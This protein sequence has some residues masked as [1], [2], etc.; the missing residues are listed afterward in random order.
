MTPFVLLLTALAGWALLTPWLRAGPCAGLSLGFLAATFFLSVEMFVFDLVGIGWNR[1]ALLLPW[2]VALGWF[3]YAQ[4]KSIAPPKL[5]WSKPNLIAFVAVAATF[6][7]WL[8]YERTLPLTLR[9]WDAWAIWLFKAKAFYLDGEIGVYL[10]RVEEFSGQPGYP[11]LIP[12]YGTFLYLWEGGVADHAAKLY[13]PAY[14][15]ALLGALH[16]LAS[17][18]ANATTACALTVS[19]G[20]TPIVAVAAFHWAGYAET[21]VSAYLIVAAGF[22]Y[23]WFREGDTTDL[24]VASVAAAAAAWTKNEGQFFFAGFA[25]LAMIKLL[26]ERRPWPHWALLLAPATTI[27]VGWS[28]VRS[29]H[30]IEAAGFSVGLSFDPSL[31]TIA[32]STVA[33]KMF[34]P[35]LFNIAFFAWGLGAI[36]ALRLRPGPA[37]WAPAG[38]VAWQLGGSV[39]AYSTG[40]NEIQWWLDTSADRLISQV[41]PLALLSLAPLFARWYESAPR[42]VPIEVADTAPRKQGRATRKRRRG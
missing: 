29:F 41:A 37:Y 9:N 10:S 30:Q 8:P 11:L 39:L 23:L 42:T 33:R 36:A 6:A 26:R 40:R 28:A 3:C 15:L 20:L 24:A 32:A 16:Y 12:L 13:S 14:W 21:A 22:L 19:A 2:A 18:I 34:S 35:D 5:D 1:A 4:R 17:R 31:F 27:V 25:A 38:L 7:V